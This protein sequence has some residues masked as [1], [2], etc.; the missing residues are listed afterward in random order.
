MGMFAAI[1]GRLL[2]L[3]ALGV[4]GCA[5][6]AARSA[7]SPTQAQGPLAP[8]RFVPPFAYEA[9][10]RGE[11]ALAA[12]RPDEA[13]LQ[14]ELATAAPE[15]DAFL[16]SRLAEALHQAGE[17]KGAEETLAQAQRVGPCEESVW[18]TRGR[19]A[20]AAHSLAEAAH[21][22][23]MALD[24]APDSSESALALMRVLRQ[25]GALSESLGVLAQTTDASSRARLRV[26]VSRELAQGSVAEARFALESWSLHGAVD[27]SLLEEA[28]SQAIARKLPVLALRLYELGP[29]RLAPRLRA[30]LAALTLDR[31]TLH[32]LLAQHHE[33]ALGGALGAARIALQARDYERAELYASLPPRGDDGQA[34]RALKVQALGAQGQVEEALSALRT[35]ED[36]EQRRTLARAQLARVGL[37]ALGAELERATH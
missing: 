18:L 32:A 30:E 9:Y 31:E 2:L 11:L 33:A 22:Y 7:P 26:V 37:G 3:G 36:A 4:A 23:R 24:C 6:T 10:V 25:Q 8:R 1:A 27:Q 5:G 15:E 20:E 12:G 17:T 14:L 13:A 19:W 35:I 21:H 34:L 16:L 28:A 29:E